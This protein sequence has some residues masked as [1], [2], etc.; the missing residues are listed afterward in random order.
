MDM[1]GL[2]MHN[3]PFIHPFIHAFIHS[4]MG[5]VNWTS[6]F[7]GNFLYPRHIFVIAAGAQCTFPLHN[8]DQHKTGIP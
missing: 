8:V 1:D 5:V 4:L 2:Y 6:G 3:H 7:L